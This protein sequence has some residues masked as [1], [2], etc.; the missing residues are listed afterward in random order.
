MKTMALAAALAVVLL[1][2]CGGSGSGGVAQSSDVSRP[3]SAAVGP[4]R[5]D[6]D[7]SAKDEAKDEAGGKTITSDVKVTAEERQIIYIATL[8]VRARDVTAAADRA[9]TL[10]TGAGGHLSKEESSAAEQQEASATLEFKIPPA[11]YQEILTVLGRDLGKRLSM[12]QGT[13]D[14]TMEVADVNSRLKSAEGAL[15]SL[16]SL[17]GKAKTIGQVLQVERE[18]QNREAELESL[19]ARQKELAAQVGMATVT[20]RLVGPAAEVLPP[21]DDPPGFLGGLAAGWRALVDFLKVV[22][23]VV[24]VVLPWLLIVA[25][26]VLLVIF[27]VRRRRTDEPATPAAPEETPAT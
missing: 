21:D 2:G 8:T 16:R 14:V 23:T 17:L 25:P 19:Q 15:A 27:L 18:I 10:V 6:A 22:V 12:T 7:Y 26:V 4:A 24:G 3:E 1:S 20:L 13:Q 9:K 5:A 11:R